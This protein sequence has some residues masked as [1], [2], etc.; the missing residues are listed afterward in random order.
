MYKQPLSLRA[1]FRLK[2]IFVRYDLVSPPPP[3]FT[4]DS[5]HSGVI[6]VQTQVL[7]LTLILCLVLECLKATVIRAI[8]KT[9]ILQV[10][11]F[12][13]SCVI[14]GRTRYWVNLLYI[15]AL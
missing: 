9:C 12:T 8:S 14:G 6:I 15:G 3:T 2:N 10:L 4:Q 7:I 5:F 13:N 11:H 1:L